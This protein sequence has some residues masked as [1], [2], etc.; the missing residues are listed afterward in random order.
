[1]N[2]LRRP[3]APIALALLAATLF[4]AGGSAARPFA[5]PRNMSAPKIKGTAMSGKT[6]VALKGKWSGNP[7]SFRYSWQRCNRA[8]KRCAS[9][10][11]PHRRSTSATYKLTSADVGTRLRV[12]ITASNA[13]GSAS[14]VSQA[15]AV[16]KKHKP[17]NQ[18]PNPPPPPPPPPPPVLPNPIP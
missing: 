15:S 7:S 8:A 2:R 16:V 9:A 13:S 5:A 18:P 14:V 12:V 10:R 1:M 4:L 11:K 6:L 17:N 3:A